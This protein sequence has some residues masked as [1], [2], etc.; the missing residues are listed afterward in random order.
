MG[1]AQHHQS[2]PL[3]ILCAPLTVLGPTLCACAIYT[4]G[5][6]LIFPFPLGTFSLGVPAFGCYFAFL[7]VCCNPEEQAQEVGGGWAYR[8]APAKRRQTAA[9]DA[10]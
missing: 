4:V 10:P 3:R 8:R 9:W 5:A 1:P 6:W 7:V 2:P